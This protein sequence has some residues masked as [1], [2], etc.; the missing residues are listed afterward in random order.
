MN[1]KYSQGVINYKLTSCS[2]M[3]TTYTNIYIED[4]TKELIIENMITESAG[5]DLN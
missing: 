5:S 4:N 1:N 3:W 2:D